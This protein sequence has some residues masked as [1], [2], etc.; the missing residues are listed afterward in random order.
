MLMDVSEHQTEPIPVPVGS[1]F[2]TYLMRYRLTWMDVA[3]AAGVRCLTVWSID[4]GQPVLPVHA[5]RVRRGLYL[6]TGEPYVGPIAIIQT[7][8]PPRRQRGGR[9]L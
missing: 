3:R 9:Q 2:H 1:A 6:L 5:I 8:E 4:H 7:E